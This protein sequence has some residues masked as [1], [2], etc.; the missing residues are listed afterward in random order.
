MF[1]SIPNYFRLYAEKSRVIKIP[2]YFII[3]T[4]NYRLYT[5]SHIFAKYS[6]PIDI[7]NADNLQCLHYP[8]STPLLSS[9][10][11]CITLTIERGE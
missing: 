7:F 4:L 10:E 11:I 1:D 8:S 5:I 6:Y 9:H 2:A 3:M